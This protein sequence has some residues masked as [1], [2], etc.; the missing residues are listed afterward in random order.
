MEITGLIV[1]VMDK[2]AGDTERGH[3]ESQQYVAKYF[4]PD[5]PRDQYGKHLVFTVFGADRI[6]QYNIQKDKEYKISFDIDA[7]ESRKTLG[8]WFTDIRAWKVEPTQADVQQAN[9]NPS[10]LI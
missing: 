6:A 4:D 1:A 8:Q 10:S 9:N 3:W 2:R 5:N 7:N